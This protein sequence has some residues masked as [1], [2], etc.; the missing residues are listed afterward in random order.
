MAQFR[1]AARSTGE[2]RATGTQL[3]WFVCRQARRTIA[4]ESP[5]PQKPRKKEKES[6]NW[7]PHA[8]SAVLLRLQLGSEGSLGLQHT[9][10][11]I[12][13]IRPHVFLKQPGLERLRG[14]T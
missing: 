2:R 13:I 12:S 14:A 10:Q 7:D 1:S 8:L 3:P 6:S 11:S 4:P 9:R 5:R